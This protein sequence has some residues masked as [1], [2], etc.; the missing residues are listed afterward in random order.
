M[1]KMWEYSLC[2]TT[3]QPVS[4]PLPMPHESAVFVRAC[5][6]RYR[7]SAIPSSE[8]NVVIERSVR[9]RITYMVPHTRS[10][11]NALYF[12][13]MNDDQI[14]AKLT[15]EEYHVLREKGTEAPFT[16][17]YVDNHEPGVY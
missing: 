3:L 16:G 9:E 12:L 10:P 6:A 8:K 14:K 2:A 5:S 17:A 4:A 7:E 15:P 13:Y 1:P 11:A